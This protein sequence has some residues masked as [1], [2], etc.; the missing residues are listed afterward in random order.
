M[1][2]GSSSVQVS[3]ICV[4]CFRPEMKMA[5]K[6]AMLDVQCAGFF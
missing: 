6:N 4:Q 1:Y 3:T 2:I 5:V